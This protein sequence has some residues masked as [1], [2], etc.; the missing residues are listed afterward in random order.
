MSLLRHPQQDLVV[1]LSGGIATLG[2]YY[3]KVSFQDPH[4]RSVQTFRLQVDTGSSSLLLAG[5]GCMN[6]TSRVKR[7]PYL[8][9]LSQAVNCTRP[10]CS[11]GF[12]NPTET[13]TAPT[14][15]GFRLKYGDNTPQYNLEASGLVASA[16]VFLANSP[17]HAVF[18]YIVQRE[19]GRWP[20]RVDGIL[21]LAF[22]RLNCNPNCFP[23]AWRQ[24]ESQQFGFT[25]CLGDGGGRLVFPRA[26]FAPAHALH[27]PL[28]Q[29][30][31]FAEH[32]FYL[33]KSLGLAIVDPKGRYLL[34]TKTSSRP[35]PSQVA[36]ID[37]GTTL[38]ILPRTM[39]ANLKQHLQTYYCHLPG[40]C[41]PNRASSTLFEFGTCLRRKPQGFPTLALVFGNAHEVVLLPPDLYFI[42]Y[43]EDVFCLGIQPSAGE[44]FI[45]G[46]TVLRGFTVGFDFQRVAFTAERDAGCGPV[47]GLGVVITKGV[48]L[49]H[50]PHLHAPPYS[51]GSEAHHP[52][53]AFMGFVFL[54]WVTVIS[55]WRI[56]FRSRTG[57]SAL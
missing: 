28:I 14:T 5:E 43:A 33:V 52:S 25:L 54:F 50:V 30:E 38:L 19:V 53:L 18:A 2:E 45:V 21:G 56:L 17:S 36:V 40:V 42:Q 48:E 24:F 57:Y 22:E 34:L 11:E 12:C 44:E 27:L 9:D 47:S 10:V 32:T 8:W 7:D 6:C 26:A 15:C 35:S 13:A 46:D 4:N 51:S 37:S 41:A 16:H 3:A 31:A 55:L 29:S 1:P 49:G 39:F 20:N 23:V